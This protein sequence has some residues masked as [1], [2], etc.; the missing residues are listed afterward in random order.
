MIFIYRFVH[1]FLG[2]SKTPLLLEVDVF[3]HLLILLRL[4]DTGHKQDAL[5]CSGM[6]CL[7]VV[8]RPE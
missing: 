1:F 5:R 2:R 7:V 8:R 6:Y 4:F 3:I